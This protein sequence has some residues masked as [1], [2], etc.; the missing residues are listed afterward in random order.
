[1]SIILI[2]LVYNSSK[3]RIT[4]V[5]IARYKCLSQS[6][7]PIFSSQIY[8]PFSMQI[9]KSRL[10][11]KVSGLTITCLVLLTTKSLATT[12][13]HIETK[14]TI[15]HKEPIIAQSPAEQT[16]TPPT[17]D[18]LSAT[19]KLQGQVIFGLNS[20]LAGDISRNT[21]FGNR[22]RLELVTGIGTG[23]LTTRLQVN[24]LGL[25]NNA[26]APVVTP[27]GTSSFGD[28][29]PTSQIGLDLLKYEV[30]IGPNTQLVVAGNGAG[31]DDFTDSINPY[32]DGDGGSGSISRFGNRPSIYYLVAGAGVGVRHKFSPT[33][34]GSVGYLASN[35]SNPASGSGLTNGGYGAIAQLTFNPN[36][37][38]KLGLTYVNAYNVTPGTG[39]NNANASGTNNMFGVQ[40]TVKVSPNL[41]FGG[42]LGYNKNSDIDGDSASPTLRERDIL[43][44]AVT[45]AFPNLGGEGNLGGILIGQEPRVTGATGTAIADNGSSLHLEGFYQV[46]INDNL[47]ITPGLIYLTAPDHNNANSGA[48]IGTVRTTFSF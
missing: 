42:W 26:G 4:N 23:T 2:L 37:N 16:K 24:G 7:V 6:L 29:N 41:A 18:Q 38:I 32:F 27:E 34:E 33:I 8:S 28:P 11:I 31:A 39:S 45:A 1:M 9:S 46:K 25:P 40:G 21:A 5:L 14:H 30:S 48:L 22:T 35:A 10:M 17:N 36:E 43:N 44:W 3:I 15:A 20:G 13:P 19:T 12:L 47:S